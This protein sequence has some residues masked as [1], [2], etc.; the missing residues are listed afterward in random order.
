MYSYAKNDN[1][2]ILLMTSP[3][4][5]LHSKIFHRL[6]FM[7]NYF[8]RDLKSLHTSLESLTSPFLPIS[9]CLKSSLRNSDSGNRGNISNS[10]S[11]YFFFI[12]VS[13][14]K[15]FMTVGV[16]S[17]QNISV[18]EPFSCS[19]VLHVLKDNQCWLLFF[20]IELCKLLVKI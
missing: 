5:S 12:F 9:P 1:S 2:S 11:F 19:V 3:K 4:L 17:T 15:S 16:I 18:L 7:S 10:L 8:V 20:S 6:S 14:T 13:Q